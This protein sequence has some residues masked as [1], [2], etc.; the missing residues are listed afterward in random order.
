MENKG[1]Y[2]SKIEVNDLLH[3]KDFAIEVPQDNAPRHLF[4]TGPNGTGKTILLKEI[5]NMLGEVTDEQNSK[6][7]SIESKLADAHNE[8]ERLEEDVEKKLRDIQQ[9]KKEYKLELQ[10]NEESKNQVSKE[11]FEKQGECEQL[12]IKLIHAENNIKT[13]EDENK[14]LIESLES[15]ELER[16]SELRPVVENINEIKQELSNL[17][18]S[19]KNNR[20]KYNH[21]GGFFMD[22]PSLLAQIEQNRV[23]IE[24]VENRLELLEAEYSQVDEKYNQK[25]EVCQEKINVITQKRELEQKVLDLLN[26]QVQIKNEEIDRLKEKLHQSSNTVIYQSITDLISTN[27]NIV[28]VISSTLEDKQ[29]II[30]LLEKERDLLKNKVEPICIHGVHSKDIINKYKKKQYLL[31]YYDDYRTNHFKEVERDLG[32]PNLDVCDIHTSKVDQFLKYLVDL[33]VQQSVALN[34]NE[35]KKVDD[36]NKWFDNFTEILRELFD[37]KKLKLLYNDRNYEFKI[38]SNKK[39]FGFTELSAGYNSAL[40]I[41]VDLMLKMISS[42]SE[43]RSY[44][45]PGIVLIDEVETHLHLAL[46]RHI[47]PMLTKFFPKIQFIVTTHSP[48]VLNSIENA[49]AYDLVTREAIN[50]LNEYSYSTLAEAYFGV[51]TESSYLTN[52]LDRFERLTSKAKLSAS[53]KDEIEELREQLEKVPEWASPNI[54]TRFYELDS[55]YRTKVMQHD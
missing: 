44:E 48:F 32:K 18:V 41:I 49:V 28:K 2:I 47:M 10:K 54:K 21:G 42:G 12:Y 24:D 31:S 17:R 19:L 6:L 22:K 50:D 7:N 9:Y 46:Q 45:M 5:G 13:I 14:A 39:K 29:Q 36:I 3:L 30:Q 55:D 37:D 38:S 1:L 27:E 8:M 34:K 25:V 26:F 53:E 43:L 4:I 51:N 33:K 20:H 35:E 40:D 16:K 52:Q 11:L 23:D 15:I